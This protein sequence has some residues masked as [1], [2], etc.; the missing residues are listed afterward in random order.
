MAKSAPL[1]GT[2]DIFPAEARAWRFLEETGRKVFERYGFG[3]LRT[4]V[5]EA[6]EVFQRGLGDETE[7][8]QKEMYTF[9]DRGG[10]SVTLRPEG[11]AG[12]MRALLNTDVLNGV[13]Q[14]VYYTGPMFRGERPAAGR[15]RQ[16][17][18]IGAEN[19]GRVAPELDA[20]CIAMLLD[21]LGELG[22]SDAV[23][24]LNTRG[25]AADRPAAAAALKDYFSRHLDVLCDDCK[26]RLEGN[27]W[28]ILDCKQAACREVIA[29]VPDYAGMFSAESRAYFEEVCRRL[30]WLGIRYEI[31]PF[32]VRGLDYYVHTVFEITHAGLGAQNAVAG[33][34]RYELLL[35]GESKPVVGV[36]F[37]AGMERL[38]MARE[39]L[40]LTAAAPELSMVFVAALGDRAEEFKV[41]FAQQ[42]R[43][44]G[45][46][47]MTEP[48]GKSLKA[49]MRAANRV[50]AR[51]AVIAGDEELARGVAVLRDLGSAEQ[52]EV[53]LAELAR[54]VRDALGC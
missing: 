38:L 25:V 36:G 50:N 12:V 7:V 14:R 33:G 23:L 1:P 20:E 26:K 19:V 6:T 45:V 22:L 10:R 11:T 16:F 40:G 39:S 15:R 8:V 35:P 17:H 54:A 49:Q 43:H 41:K 2:A 30:D 51:I 42:L 18:Q 29:G 9:E 21:F 46:A 44:D 5:F 4:P 31:D 37:A 28:R 52:R 32:L 47:V 24:K 27:V 48:A 3:E 13:E 34:G 53:G